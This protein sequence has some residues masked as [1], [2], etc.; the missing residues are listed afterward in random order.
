MSDLMKVGSDFGGAGTFKPFT[1]AISGAQRTADAHGRFSDAAAAGRLFCGGSATLITI[2]NATFTVATTGATAT[3]VI[4]VWNPLSS[5]KTLSVLQA[6]LT[7]VLTAVAATGAGGFVWMVSRGNDA[8]STGIV[9][10]SRSTFVASGSVAKV[11]AGTALTGMT[12]TLATLCGSGLGGGSLENVSFTATAVAM[13]TTAMPT[14]E[15]IDGSISVPPGGVLALM[16]TT[17]PVAHS[18]VPGIM[19][20]ELP[21]LLQ[22]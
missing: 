18:A 20:E 21:L 8:I 1:S 5:A 11:F 19:W 3:P 2:N 10:T 13:Q 14:V 6:S 15:N 12:G 22:V 9:P 17:T 4:G 16:A 7:L